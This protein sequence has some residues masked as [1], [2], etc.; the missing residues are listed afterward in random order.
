MST[1]E[2]YKIA[3]IAQADRM[4]HLRSPF[5]DRSLRIKRN[6][7]GR[8]VDV[9]SIYKISVMYSQ[10]TVYTVY[11]ITMSY[12]FTTYPYYVDRSKTTNNKKHSR[13]LIKTVSA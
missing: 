8:R 11:L 9:K 4:R 10:V 1:G 2:Q 12:A 7:R 5:I 13:H 6:I 3:G